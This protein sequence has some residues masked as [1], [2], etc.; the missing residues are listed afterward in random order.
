MWYILDCEP[1]AQIICGVKQG[2][3]KKMLEEAMNSEK[4][5]EYLNYIDV[6]KG[7]AIFIPSGTIHAL[8]GKTLVA[9]V[10][11]NSNL[12]Y[13]VYDWG[14]VGKDGKPR[15]LHIQKALD[16]INLEQTP[17]IKNIENNSP[18]VRVV[19]SEF[20]MT[21]KINVKTCF[22]EEITGQSFLAFNVIEGAGKLK[23]QN[24]TYEITKGDSFILPANAKQYE[25]QGEMELL[26]SYL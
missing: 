13:R 26:E 6:H 4:I 24:Q 7:D 21:D 17:Q 9:E 20:F 12:T 10:Q 19:Q 8:L 3:T 25:L 5:A 15:E 23:L 22:Q 16:V 14:R 18:K 11:Q 2:V 1:D